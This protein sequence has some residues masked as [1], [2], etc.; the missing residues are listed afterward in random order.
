MKSIYKYGAVGVLI[1]VIVMQLAYLLADNEIRLG[2]Y[3]RISYFVSFIF[4]IVFILGLV[5]VYKNRKLEL[6][7]KRF[8]GR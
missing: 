3:E 7:K 8:A 4:A 5:I 1:S 6:E 2:L